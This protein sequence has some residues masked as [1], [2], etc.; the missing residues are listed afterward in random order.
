MK[1]TSRDDKTLKTCAIIDMDEVCMIM[2][3][4]S[5]G[6]FGLK[7]FFKNRADIF[8]GRDSEAIRNKDFLELERIWQKE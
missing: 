4:E 8:L 5:N 1:F 6:I 2:K 7:L 3:A